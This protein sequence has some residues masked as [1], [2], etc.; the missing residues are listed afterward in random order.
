LLK[1]PEKL[2]TLAV[3]ALAENAA[4]PAVASS[5]PSP[6]L[7]HAIAP[8]ANDPSTIARPKFREDPCPM[9]RKIIMISL[10]LLVSLASGMPVGTRLDDEDHR[11]ADP[12][13][14]VRGPRHFSAV[15]LS[16]LPLGLRTSIA[17]RSLPRS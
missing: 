9:K 3:G 2:E 16:S 8:S 13:L 4:P 12:T 10:P 1:V 14:M 5:L 6:E 11:Q 17:S 7:P 15:G